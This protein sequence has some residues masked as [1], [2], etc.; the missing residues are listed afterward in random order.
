[1][2]EAVSVAR[3]ET[4]HVL[5]TS[6]GFEPGFKGGGPVRSIAN[7]VDTAPSEINIRLVTADRDLGSNESYPGLSGSWASRGRTKVFYLHGR[8]VRQW[9]KLIRDLRRERFDLLYVNSLWA[10]VATVLPVIAVR[11]GIVSVSRIMLAPRGELSGGALAVKA[12]KKK[13]VFSS[14]QRVLRSM[15]V[16]WH[17]TAPHEADDIRAACRWANVVVVPNQ[18]SLP[19]DPLPVPAEDTRSARLVYISRIVKNKNLHL[20]VTALKEV[21]ADVA[22][23]IYGPIEDR[24]YWSAC[25]KAISELPSNVEVSYRGELPPDAVRNAFSI[26]DAFLLPT[27]GE[28][29]GHVIAESLSASCP[30]ICSDKTPWTDVLEQGGGRV[31]RNLTAEHFGG[32]VQRIAVMTSEERTRQRHA[33]GLAYRAWQTN[34]AD[35]NILETVRA[36]LTAAT[37]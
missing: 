15:R 35:L 1:M 31:V 5:M 21:E 23:D 25:Q 24:A 36:S 30:V 4:F 34:S 6:A 33:A 9:I 2:T 14:W 7:I 17:A 11:L 27:S 20:A 16:E 18:T 8:S 29:F 22:F 12:T 19:R 10:P 37:R 3:G 32:E 26:Y 13:L 28:N